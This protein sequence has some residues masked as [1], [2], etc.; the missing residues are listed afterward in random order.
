[1]SRAGLIK[2]L[3]SIPEASV[4]LASALGANIVDLITCY[5]MLLVCRIISAS[6]RHR[7]QYYTL[8]GHCS[9]ALHLVLVILRAVILPPLLLSL[10]YGL[11]FPT[12]EVS[13]GGNYNLVF[14][15]PS[16]RRFLSPAKWSSGSRPDFFHGSFQLHTLIPYTPLSLYMP[17]AGFLWTDNLIWREEFGVFGSTPGLDLLQS[18]LENEP[19]RAFFAD[20]IG[21][22]HPWVLQLA[23]VPVESDATQQAYKR[24]GSSL[25]SEDAVFL[26]SRVTGRFLG[27]VQGKPSIVDSEMVYLPLSREHDLIHICYIGGNERIRLTFPQLSRTYPDSSINTTWV[28][29]YDQ[30]HDSGLSLYNPS[31]N[32]Y[33]ATSFRTYIDYDGYASKNDTVQHVINRVLE[34][35]CT[36]G[37]SEQASTFWVIEGNPQNL[38]YNGFPPLRRGF[39]LLRALSDL[40]RWRRK[41]T[42]LLEL[43]DPFKSQRQHAHEYQLAIPLVEEAVLSFF[44]FLHAYWCLCRRR[45]WR[46]ITLRSDDGERLRTNIFVFVVP[47]WVHVGAYWLFKLNRTY[48]G[49]FMVVLAM[50]GIKLLLFS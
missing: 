28:L 34:A 29:Y 31:Q 33:L 9:I 46:W 12:S 23:S 48:S 16:Y 14:L 47:V 11:I 15:A 43:P 44:L 32:C 19:H 4:V 20:P 50:S 13:A 17:R 18:S 7:E 24:S 2:E 45:K 5:S 1:M 22:R 3:F 41:Y 26:R 37:A 27:V 21:R 10:I 39:A 8:I 40:R 49:Q 35:T 36:R 25:V 6:K 30:H 42:M 38:D